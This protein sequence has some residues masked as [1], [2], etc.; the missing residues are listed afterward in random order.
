MTGIACCNRQSV[1]YRR[2]T[3]FAM[4]NT[5]HHFKIDWKYPADLASDDNSFSAS[6]KL[7][8]DKYWAAVMEKLVN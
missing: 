5:G 6:A 8:S 7:D 2:I 3:S 1:S 4:S